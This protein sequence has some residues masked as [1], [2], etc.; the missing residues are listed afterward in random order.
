M[1]VKLEGDFVKKF[2]PK[3]LIFEIDAESFLSTL[4]AKETADT[5][6]Y[7]NTEIHPNT[8]L[9]KYAA[10]LDSLFLG[11]YDDYN[12]EVENLESN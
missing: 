2:V 4:K 6:I 8:N 7:D 12:R 1:A 3:K 10:E 9:A 11:M 5:F